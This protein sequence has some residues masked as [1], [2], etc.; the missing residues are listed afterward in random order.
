MTSLIKEL[1]NIARINLTSKR[2]ILAPSK[3]AWVEFP[4]FN[5]YRATQT[6]AIV[7]WPATVH[8]AVSIKDTVLKHIIQAGGFVPGKG[9]KP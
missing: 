6:I 4:Q 9:E 5:P 1:K 3:E 8:T 7:H 2:N